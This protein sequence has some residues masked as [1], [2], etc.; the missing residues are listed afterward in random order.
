MHRLLLA[1]VAAA[2]LWAAGPPPAAAETPKA[3][4]SIVTTFKDDLPTLDPA[5]GYDWQNW[6]VIKSLFDGL[7]DYKPGTTELAPDLAESFTIS[8][9][10]KTYVFKLRDGVKFHNGRPLVAADI[11]YSIERAINPKTQC[12]GQSYFSMIKGYED[13]AAGK[14]TDVSGITTPDDHTVQFEL[15]QPDATFLHIMAINFGYAVPKEEVEKWGAD[16]GKHPVGT[17]AFKLGEWVLGQRLVLEK[18]PDYHVKGVPYLD[19]ITF[20]FGQDPTVALLRL[21]KGEVDLLGD[22]IPPAQFLQV[23]QDPANKDLWVAGA[24]MNTDYVTMNVKV[25]P[26]DN[27]KVRQAVNMAINKD[28]VI[29]IINGRAKVANQVLPPSL[30]GYDTAH[31]GYPYDPAKAKALLAEAGYPD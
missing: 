30:P 8:D 25:K 5:V 1:V 31:E 18:N 10:G 20:E 24:Q 16:F 28:R 17:G 11:K 9:D 2:L 19:K 3:G 27:L 22:G 13:A 4:G 14:T 23:T 21:K 6:T 12:P 15:N 26:F 29:Q 7:M